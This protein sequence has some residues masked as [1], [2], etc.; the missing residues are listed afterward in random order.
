MNACATEVREATTVAWIGNSSTL[1]QLRVGRARTR[2]SKLQLAALD[3]GTPGDNAMLVR[4]EVPEVRGLV[5]M[6]RHRLTVYVTAR[7][8]PLRH[9]PA[10]SGVQAG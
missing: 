4:S 2:Q 1:D 8:A 7:C 3:Q 6:C 5:L 9:T 10:E